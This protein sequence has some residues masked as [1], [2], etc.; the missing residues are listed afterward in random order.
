M[1]GLFRRWQQRRQQVAEQA[2]Q[3]QHEQALQAEA[4]AEAEAEAQAAELEQPEAASTEAATSD[5]AD[6]PDPDTIEEGGSF[7]EFLKEGVDPAKRQQALKALWSQPQY[8]VTDGLTD[9]SLD[10]AA[11]PLLDKDV[12]AELVNNVFRHSKEAVE[13]LE[14][15]DQAQAALDDA[16]PQLA[17]PESS[18]ADTKAIVADDSTTPE[19]EADAAPAADAATESTP[20]SSA[21]VAAT[22]S[23][24][25]SSPHCDDEDP[26]PLAD[27]SLPT[28]PTT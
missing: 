15:L 14:Q 7:A 9:Y 12:A 5:A 27:P 10:Y 26:T 13:R 11:Q 20:T 25:P 23:T 24:A 4:E 19:L 2:Q 8:N 22:E 16:K 3:T 1:S 18:L 21:E 17:P 28:D 6:L